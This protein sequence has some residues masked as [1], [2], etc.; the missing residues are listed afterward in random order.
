MAGGGVYLEN[1]GLE[2][3]SCVISSNNASYGGGVFQVGESGYVTATDSLIQGNTAGVH[4]GGLYVEGSAA[5]TNTTLNQ[6]IAAVHGGGLSVDKGSVVLIGGTVSNNR[7]AA[8]N[9][10]GINLN[11]GLSIV[12][13]Q[14]DNNTAG[15]SGGGVTQ[16]NA[17]QTVTIQRCCVLRQHGY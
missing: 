1:G 13:T 12:G 6:N 9:G 14:F 4:G 8:G 17:G 10:G 2:L 15:D 7:A 16:W 5:L 3:V 11:N